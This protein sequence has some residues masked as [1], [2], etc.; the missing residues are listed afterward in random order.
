M[1]NSA[2]KKVDTVI[3]SIWGVLRLAHALGFGLDFIGVFFFSLIIIFKVVQLL[4]PMRNY[5]YRLVT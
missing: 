1:V 2:I 5:V 3:I 4:Y